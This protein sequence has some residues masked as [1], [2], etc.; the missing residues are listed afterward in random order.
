MK[1]TTDIAAFLKRTGAVLTLSH[2]GSKF[3]A[4]VKGDECASKYLDDALEN[5]AEAMRR[6]ANQ[7][8]PVREAKPE[9]K[10]VASN[11]AIAFSINLTPPPS[12]PAVNRIR[13][14]A[15]CGTVTD[16][17]GVCPVCNELAIGGDA[18]VG[19]AC[20]QTH[21][22]PATSG[23]FVLG[24]MFGGNIGTWDFDWATNKWA[25]VIP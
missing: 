19:F 1:T 24:G 17:G 4:H 25:K 18:T 15:A 5:L 16:P 8:A 2:D 20:A 14:M 6:R 22:W 11:K 9:P 10:A 21:R 3:L 23:R 12:T 7:M 13:A